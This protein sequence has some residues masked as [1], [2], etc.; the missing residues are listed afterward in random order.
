MIETSDNNE[1]K[2]MNVLLVGNNPTEIGVLYASLKSFENPRFNTDT[3]FHFNNIFRRI[4]KFRP[5]SI[6]IDDRFNRTKLNRLIKRIH[7]NPRTRD[8]PVTLLKSNNRDLGLTAD[9]DNYVLKENLSAEN[10]YNTILNSR[11][12][13]RTSIY[14]Y[15]SYKKSR[16]FLQ[17]IWLDLRRM[18]WWIEQI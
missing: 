14:L 2:S 3:A 1:E 6:L 5:A 8:I 17:K 16:G 15:K 13:R 12:L 10:L 4:I 18:Y 11:Q 7:R 9:I